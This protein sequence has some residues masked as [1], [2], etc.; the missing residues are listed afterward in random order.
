MDSTNGK[1]YIILLSIHGRIRGINPELGIDSD[2]GG[3]VTY[4]LEL[5]RSLSMNENVAQVDLITRRIVDSKFDTAYAEPFETLTPKARIVRLEFGPRR[6]LRKENLWPHLDDLSDRVVRHIHQVGRIPDVIHG[7]YADAAYVGGQTA[8]LLGVPFIFTGHSLGR[9]KWKRLRDSGKTNAEIEKRFNIERRIEAEEFGL[10]LASF[11]VTSTHQEIEEQYAIYS[12]YQPKRMVVIPPGIDQERFYPQTRNVAKS[13]ISRQLARFL[14]HPHKP[15]ILCLA[16]PDE[17][18]NVPALVDAYA[19]N[20]KLRDNANLVLVL[21]NRTKLDNLSREAR[22]VIGTVLQKIDDYDLYGSIAFPKTHSPDDVPDLYRLASKTRGI[23]V[24]PALNEPFGLTL[25]EAS[26]CGL[27]IVATNDGGPKD[28]VQNCKNG[29]LVDPFDT[30]AIGEAIVEGLSDYSKWKT[31]SREG[32]KGV[33]K[34]YTWNSHVQSYLRMVKKVRSRAVF[35]DIYTSRR[36]KLIKSDRLIVTDI[37]NTLLGDEDSLAEFSQKLRDKG[38][39]VGFGVASGRTAKSIVNV[40]N[41]HNIQFPDLIIASVGTEIYYGKKQTEDFGWSQHINYQWYPE[42]IRGVLSELP[43]LKLQAQKNQRRFKIS[44]NLDPGKPLSRMTI[45][46]YL[47]HHDIPARVIHSHNA[48]VDILP[49]RAS[50]GLALRYIGIK[51]GFPVER[52]LT[53]GDSGNDADMLSGDILGVV[54]GNYSSELQWL[55]GKGRIYFA[56]KNYASGLLEGINHYNFFDEIKIPGE[57][58]V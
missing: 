51:W 3:Q 13:N 7:H 42:K 58:D 43:D 32:L 6:F 19:T 38:E 4:L 29:L 1:L 41:E 39:K 8:R 23:F 45:V 52:I 53:A 2:T 10:D 34:H 33:R 44:Y 26:A 21:G 22:R 36:S 14:V 55:R 24:N 25:L 49:I 18:K 48:Y 5:A 15:M 20:K 40:L 35:R 31:W 30:N 16:R 54:V 9:V 28:I 50:K 37:D 57:D 46:R 47:R 12:N 11:V 27:P 56:D 17:K